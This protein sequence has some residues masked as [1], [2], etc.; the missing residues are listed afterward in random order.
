MDKNAVL[1]VMLIVVVIGIV[2]LI[3]GLEFTERM[4]TR[5]RAGDIIA[6]CP[7]P[8]ND[9]DKLLFDCKNKDLVSPSDLLDEE[10]KSGKDK[11]TAYRLKKDMEIDFPKKQS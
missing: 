3:D 1:W 7:T 11:Y 10:Y 4:A 9:K 6:K 2:W 8:N 5:L